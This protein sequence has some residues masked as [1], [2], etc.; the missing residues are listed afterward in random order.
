MLFWSLKFSSLY[1]I[2]SRNLQKMMLEDEM[3]MHMLMY[4]L[5]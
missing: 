1:K 5:K 2:F 3:A 4:V